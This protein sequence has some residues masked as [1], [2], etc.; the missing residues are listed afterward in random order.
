M[1][2]C[3]NNWKYGFYFIYFFNKV[4]F[5]ENGGLQD[6][7][8]FDSLLLNDFFEFETCL[9]RVGVVNCNLFNIGVFIG[10]IYCEIKVLFCYYYDMGKKEIIEIDFVIFNIFYF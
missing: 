3:F 6:V 9:G 10:N 5:F 7:C 4:V 2:Y 1:N 8:K